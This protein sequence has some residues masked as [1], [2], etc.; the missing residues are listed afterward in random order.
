[1]LLKLMSELYVRMRVFGGCVCLGDV[2]V[3]GMCVF[4]GCVCLGDVCVWGMC[5]FGGCVCLGD[6]CAEPSV[7]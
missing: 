6:V 2:C 3:W 5:V 4:G 1:M 7:S